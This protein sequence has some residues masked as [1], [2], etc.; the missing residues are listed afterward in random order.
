ML[1]FCDLRLIVC[2]PAISAA[3]NT[4]RRNTLVYTS[5]SCFESFFVLTGPFLQPQN[6]VWH[7]VSLS[8]QFLACHYK[9]HANK[10]LIEA[11]DALLHLHATV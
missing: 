8:N 10:Q 4:E 5:L 11:L 2:R 9:K 7:L 1:C 6:D 3:W